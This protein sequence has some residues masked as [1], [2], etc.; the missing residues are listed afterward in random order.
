LM[1]AINP[2]TDV[3]VYWYSASDMSRRGSSSEVTS[4]EAFGMYLCRLD[5]IH[6]LRI[7]R[8]GGFHVGLSFSFE[9][10]K[11]LEMTFRHPDEE[12]LR[13]YL[14]TFRQF[15]MENEP[16]FVNRV[17]RAAKR[18]IRSDQLQEALAKAMAEYRAARTQGS[19]QMT[20]DGVS[21]EPWVILDLW[22]NGHYFHSDKRKAEELERLVAVQGP[23]SKHVA[24]DLVVETSRYL[25]ALANVIVQAHRGSLVE[26]VGWP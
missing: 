21:P 24:L 20:V 14:M 9:A 17:H 26:V 23:L 1:R 7:I 22:L 8:E 25:I 3:R 11:K 16:V 6:S 12:D 2:G 18:E 10:A 4:A 19:V 5:E 13:S 15:I